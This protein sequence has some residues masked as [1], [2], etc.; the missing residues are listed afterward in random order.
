MDLGASSHIC[1]NK[2]VFSQLEKLAFP[3][4]FRTVSGNATVS[5]HSGKVTMKLPE[6]QSA[7]GH[8]TLHD[9]VLMEDAPANLLSQGTLLAKGW[10]VD[11]TQHGGM[12]SKH[13]INIPVYKT[14]TEGTLR[15]FK[16][17]LKKDYYIQS[18]Q[19]EDVG[20]LDKREKLEDLYLTVQDKDTIQGWHNRL[21]HMGVSVE[22][23]HAMTS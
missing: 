18:G 15:A 10:D 11:I 16:L 12:I 21:G 13:G 23:W 20:S 9:V 6:D 2:D 1:N 7:I 17:P 19:Q 5:E 14:G 4:R 8:L 22:D 3:K